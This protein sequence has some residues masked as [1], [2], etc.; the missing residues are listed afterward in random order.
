MLRARLAAH[1]DEQAAADEARA[2][3]ER[4]RRAAE[5][6]AAEERA[7]QAADVAPTPLPP[8]RPAPDEDGAPP[9]SA[10]KRAELAA[11]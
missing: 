6:K 5:A 7:A 4:R 3:A 8:L 11:N 9:R 10:R 2:R 1:L